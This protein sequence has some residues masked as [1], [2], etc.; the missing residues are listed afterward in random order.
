MLTRLKT[1]C[2][3]ISILILDKVIDAALGKDDM[4]TYKKLS[5]VCNKNMCLIWA[6]FCKK[7]IK[8]EAPRS[9]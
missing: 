1:H 3:T 8:L 4:Q 7:K 2:F 5:E 6:K 9:L